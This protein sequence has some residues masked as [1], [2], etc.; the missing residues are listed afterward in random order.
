M[1]DLYATAILDPAS[2]AARASELEEWARAEV[3]AGE[4]LRAAMVGTGQTSM[5]RPWGR[6]D[7]WLRM[8]IEA[9]ERLGRPPPADWLA[10]L[11]DLPEV[12]PGE[13][14]PVVAG[15]KSGWWSLWEVRSDATGRARDCV[16]LF[17]SDAGAVRPDLAERLWAVLAGSPD[18]RTGSPLKAEILSRLWQLGADHGWRAASALA[19][20][21]PLLAPWLVLRLV[22]RFEELG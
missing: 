12:V 19:G 17:A 18:V 5:S 11:E 1:D 22:V 4:P 6:M 2:L 21:N 20:E 3:A 16:A 8:C 14:V 7:H 15:E 13:P 9:R 10:A